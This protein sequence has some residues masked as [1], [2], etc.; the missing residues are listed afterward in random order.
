MLDDRGLAAAGDEDHL[1]DPRLARLVDRV[2]DQRPVDDR[3]HFL[4]DRLGRGKETGAETGDGKHGFADR[5]AGVMGRHRRRRASVN[6]RNRCSHGKPEIARQPIRSTTSWSCFVR[7]SLLP[8]NR[9]KAR[10]WTRSSSRA[11]SACRGT[12]PIS[13]AKNAALTL[14]PCALLTD[15]PLTLRNLPRL[16]DID[17][18]QH[19]MNQFGVSTTIAGSRPEDFGRVMTLE[20]PRDHQHRRAL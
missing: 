1:L 15:E 5:F 20:A 6:L 16:A 2:L 8:R 3:Q 9:A 14:L 19:L 11:A 17:G 13:G 12:I 7:A 18:F 4:G 10:R